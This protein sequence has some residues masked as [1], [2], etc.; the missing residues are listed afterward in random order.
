[1]VNFKKYLDKALELV[2]GSILV[3]MVL[4]VMW[5]VIART[6]LNNPS[7]LTEEFVRFSLVWLAMLAS[8]YVVGKKSHLAVTL[9]SDNLNEKNQRILEM[10]IQVLFVLFAAIIMIYGGS[11]AASLTMSQISPSLGIPMGFIYLSVPVSGVLLLVYSLMNLFS[12]IT[13]RPLEEPT[14]EVIETEEEILNRGR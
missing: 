5:Q 9:L 3:I 7:T 8:A 13:N 10:I 14:R 11:K 2:C 6:I 1:M 4:V 12:I